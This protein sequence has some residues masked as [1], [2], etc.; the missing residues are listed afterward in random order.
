MGMRPHHTKNK[1]D[2]GV[3]H[4]KLDL[5]KK[6][7]GVLLPLTEHEAFDLVA[8]KDDVFYRIQVK[9]RAAIRGTVHV[10]FRTCWADRRGVHNVPIDKTSVDYVCLYCPDSDECYY[11]DPKEFNGS[12][13]LRLT[14]TANNQAKGVLWAGD[15]RELRARGDSN[16]RPET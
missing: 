6:G 8:F 14:P 4:A 2:L 7:F 16:A 1:G 15:F 3:F 9:Y 10:P 5:V 12:V 13:T 11:V